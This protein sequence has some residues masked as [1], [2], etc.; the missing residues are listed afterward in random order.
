MSQPLWVENANLKRI[1][2]QIVRLIQGIN[3]KQ[4]HI[5]IPVR[6]FTIIL[7]KSEI[8]RDK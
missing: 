4:A 2:N 8:K 6:S 1:I 5:Q 3:L 7:D